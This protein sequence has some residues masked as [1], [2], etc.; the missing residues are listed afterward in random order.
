MLR[1]LVRR[2]PRTLV[3][4]LGSLTVVFLLLHMSGDPARMLVPEDASNADIAFVRQHLGLDQPLYEQWAVFMGH[5]AQ[6][7]FGTSF[8]ERRPAMDAVLERF[9]ATLELAVVSMALTL[10]IALPVGVIAAVKRGKAIDHAVTITTMMGRSMP[11]FW[12][13]IMLI[14]VFSV[15]L[16]WLPVSGQGSW[17]HLVLPSITL[18][19]F[20]APVLLRLVRS[21]MLEVLQEDYIRTARA[22]G[23]GSRVIL[24]RHAMRNASLPLLTM[25]GLQVGALVGGTAITEAVFAWPGLGQLLVTAVTKLDYPIVQAATALIAVAIALTNLAVD[26]SYSYLDPRV[27]AE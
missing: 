17:Q 24:F 12:L 11:T 22:K 6:G 26:L 5:V 2:L 9:P 1:I 3:V 19:A 20:M 8:Y 18:A 7:D 13:G 4:I 25:A 10:L 14:V 27:K 16:R 15:N 21:A 23:V